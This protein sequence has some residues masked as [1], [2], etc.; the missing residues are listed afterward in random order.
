LELRVKVHKDW[1]DDVNALKQL[2]YVKKK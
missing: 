1:R 2:G